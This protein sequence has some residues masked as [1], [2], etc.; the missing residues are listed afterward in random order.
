MKIKKIILYG[1]ALGL[2]SLSCTSPIQEELFDQPASQR[3]SQ[4]DEL[5]KKVLEENPD[6]WILS[7]FIGET[8]FG[9]YNYHLTFSDGKV[10]VLSESKTTPK[11][12]FYSIVNVGG[13]MLSFDLFNPVLMDLATPSARLPLPNADTDF[14]ILSYNEKDG[15]FS[16][17]GPKTELLMTLTKF[18]G[19][20]QEFFK[21][22][23]E[24]R[25]AYSGV[26]FSDITTSEGKVK[27]E[28]DD[29]SAVFQF[30]KQTKKVSVITTPTGFKLYEPITIA[31]ETFSEFTLSDDGEYLQV[32]EKNIKVKILKPD[33]DINTKPWE[34][35]FGKTNVS[36][37]LF[38][39]FRKASSENYKTYGELLL[40]DV[41]IGNISSNSSNT[42]TGIL[43]ESFD[44]N[45]FKPWPVS[46]VLNFIGTNKK[47]QLNI[48]KNKQ[49]V[50]WK[51]YLHLD[52]LLDL[53]IQSAPYNLEYDNPQQPTKVKLTS[54][55]DPN[56][57]FNI[58]EKK[59]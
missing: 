20:K 38:S 58:Q 15:V 25:S 34:L 9:G 3:L 45:T 49:G 21:K 10:S 59:P 5:Y 16:L 2:V 32:K 41:I 35:K 18:Q 57:W 53:I 31:G 19:D 47:N 40:S 37:K 7:Y 48:I 23:K 13:P 56:I 33:F 14:N 50:N 24:V 4:A 22:I 27:F 17:R 51:F 39:E 36:A 6:G 55:A 30:E 8:R 43:F 54:E 26:V 44:L 52:P 28:I 11:E 29:R 12:S 46:Y 1:F 42:T